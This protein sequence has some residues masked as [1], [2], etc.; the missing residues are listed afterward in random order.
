MDPDSEEARALREEC[1]EDYDTAVGLIA[2]A[3]HV[4]GG[5]LVPGHQDSQTH[6]SEG[7]QERDWTDLERRKIRNGLQSLA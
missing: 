2:E 4:A 7:R 1:A 5:L 3:D 6:S